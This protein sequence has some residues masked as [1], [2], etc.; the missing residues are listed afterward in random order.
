M[1]TKPPRY[2]PIKGVRNFSFSSARVRASG[3]N[4]TYTPVLMAADTENIFIA[5]I[6]KRTITA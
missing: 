3:R 4:E 2:R 1:H 6:P 5:K